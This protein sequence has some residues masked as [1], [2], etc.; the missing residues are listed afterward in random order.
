MNKNNPEFVVLNETINLIKDKL[1]NLI[2]ENPL[3]YTHNICSRYI[4]FN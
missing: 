1:K 4:N 2:K 3:A